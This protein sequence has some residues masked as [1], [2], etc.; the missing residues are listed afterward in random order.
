MA[1]DLFGK[2]Y[3]NPTKSYIYTNMKCNGESADEISFDI[4]GSNGV[5]STNENEL[6]KLNLSEVHVGLTQYTT[7]MKIINPYSFI[8]VKGIDQ[9]EAYT[10]KAYGIVT[11]KAKEIPDWMYKTT[12]IF[13]IKYVDEIGLKVIKCIVAGGSIDDDKTFIEETQEVLDHAK[14][15]INV[16]YE[17]DYIYFTSSVL[18][19]DFWISH[20]ELWHYLGDG[21]IEEDFPELFNKENDDKSGNDLGFGYDNAWA[22]A[23][24]NIYSPNS[25]ETLN[26]Y[27]TALSEEQYRSIYNILG[28]HSISDSSTEFAEMYD[29][30]TNILFNT[31]LFEDLTKYLPAIKYRNGAMKGCVVLATYPQFNAENIPDTQRALKI[32]HLIDR[33]E[34][35]YTSPE[36]EFSGLPLYVRVIRDVVD[37]YYSQ[38]E[39]DVFKKWSNGYSY[40]N[41]ND[42]WLDPGEIPVVPLDGHSNEWTH[43][44]V[45]N[46]YVLNTIYKDESIYD[47]VGLFGYATYLSKHNL[48]MT[49]GQF[50]ARTT[51]DDDESKKTRNLIPSFLIYNPNSFPVTVKYMTFV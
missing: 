45:P 19:Y 20:I 3:N 51:V 39:Y 32:A 2:Y 13:H 47:A 9:G 43:S 50:Y 8:Y 48:W 44:H 21:N 25:T 10:T 30:S 38:Y 36:N 4:T 34:D 41:K 17:D 27:T 24:S 14:I 42:E 26:A 40:M 5:I 33:L 16:T 29:V 28:T 22:A 7:D 15:P 35:Y 37:S 23:Q 12:M 11:D 18:G 1:T 46:Y 6:S 31:Y 49:M